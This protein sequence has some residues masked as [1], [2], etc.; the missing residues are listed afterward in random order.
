MMRFRPNVVVRG[1]PAWAEDDWRRIRIGR[2]E[3]RLVKGCARCVLTTLDPETAAK[4]ME[5]L[6]SL[7]RHRRWDGATWFAMN[8]VP[9][10]PGATIGVGDVVEVLDAV[11]PGN[12]PPR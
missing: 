10:T 11:E 9:D 6:M 7:A 4:G 5:P 8:L 2:A 3:F 12:G 1:A